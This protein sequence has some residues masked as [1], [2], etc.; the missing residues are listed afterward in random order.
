MQTEHSAAAPGENFGV[1]RLRR[2]VFDPLSTAGLMVTT[3]A[4]GG[5]HNVALAGDTVLH[6][7][8]DEFVTAKW[9]ATLDSRTAAG[10][11]LA[12]RSLFDARWERRTGRG[13]QY[14]WQVAR[15][16]AEFRPELGFLPR[17]DFT[18]ANVVA[19]WYVF[20]DTLPYF[21][22]IYPGALA[23]TTWRNRDRQVESG[24]YAFWVQWDTKRGGGGWIEPKWFRENVLTPFAI[25]GR[26]Q[27][28]AGVYDFADL[29]LVHTM[30]SGSVLRTDVDLRTG[31]YFDGRRTQLILTP[32]WNASRHLELGGS[33][34]LTHLD[35]THRGQ[36][37]TIQLAGV[38]VRT[39]L[40]ARASGNALVQYNSTTGRLDL[41]VRLRYNVREGTDL[42]IVYNEGLDT[43]RTVSPADG[44]R[45]PW[46]LARALIVKYSHT[47]AF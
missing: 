40:D 42:W 37:A 24:Q 27:I 34:Q 7:R 3:Y 11:G 41:N 21:R 12:G 8:G 5:R 46:S 18:T 31:T 19:N 44:L 35:F 36:R 29:Q 14:S 10:I 45:G 30:P 23:F 43:E 4:G 9:A 2:A 17:R 32:T 38:R 13:L 47:L 39:A 28:P 6:V 20:T 26:V 22:R 15:A 33:Y 25:G 16:G 1:L